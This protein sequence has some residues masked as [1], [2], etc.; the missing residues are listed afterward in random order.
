MPREH[1]NLSSPIPSSSDSGD[2]VLSDSQ[3][4]LYELVEMPDMALPICI[5][6]CVSPVPKLA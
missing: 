5:P 1:R 4:F 3:D 6:G 2:P